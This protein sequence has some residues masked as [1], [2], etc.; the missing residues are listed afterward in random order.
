MGF[1]RAVVIHEIISSS[2][3]WIHQ[4]KKISINQIIMRATYS[5]FLK[6]LFLFCVCDYFVYMYIC[7]KCVLN[8]QGGHK[9]VLDPLEWKSQIVRDM[10]VLGVKPSSSAIIVNVPNY[11]A[12][13]PAQ[14]KWRSHWKLQKETHHI[15]LFCLFFCFLV[16]LFSSLIFIYTNLPISKVFTCK[17]FCKRPPSWSHRV[18]LSL[19]VTMMLGWGSTDIVPD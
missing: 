12:I 5:F 11:W 4:R 13:F 1:S 7:T 2:V 15:S 14:E 17:S 8:A 19:P 9:R 10:W 6:Y 3:L 16:M 18:L